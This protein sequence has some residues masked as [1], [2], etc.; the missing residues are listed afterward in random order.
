M[1]LKAFGVY[2]NGVVKVK[3]KNETFMSSDLVPR[4]AKCVGHLTRARGEMGEVC[5]LGRLT[6]GKA[7]IVNFLN[8]ETFE[9]LFKMRN[10]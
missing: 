6:D 4:L 7:A 9:L 5:V 10:V 1:K 3:L 2:V 8:C